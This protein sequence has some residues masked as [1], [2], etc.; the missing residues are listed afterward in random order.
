M[1]WVELGGS[2]RCL[3]RVQGRD[4]WRYLE[5]PYWIRTES[6]VALLRKRKRSCGRER[7]LV[8]KG[9]VVVLFLNFGYQVGP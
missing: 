9:E 2:C 1:V 8:L 6:G 5:A 3:D 7:F 4:P